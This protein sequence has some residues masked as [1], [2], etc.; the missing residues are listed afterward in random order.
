MLMSG[1]LFDSTDKIK[2]DQ[3][4]M[5]FSVRGNCRKNDDSNQGGINVSKCKKQ[6]EFQD[7]C[8]YDRSLI[9]HKTPIAQDELW[10]EDK[11]KM[12]IDWE[13]MCT[14]VGELAKYKNL[15]QFIVLT[16]DLYGL[17]EASQSQKVH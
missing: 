8:C 15:D 9:P 16:L 3:E 14:L 4:R 2:R 13:F 1:Q 17:L 7:L 5:I 10:L 6:R 11:A 12:V